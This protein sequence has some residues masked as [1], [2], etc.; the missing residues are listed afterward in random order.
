MPAI[1]PCC[2]RRFGSQKSQ[3]SRSARTRAFRDLAGFGRR[4]MQVSARDAED[5]VLYQLAAVAGVASAE[6]LRLQHVKPHGALFN[7]AARDARSGVGHR[8]GGGGI[9]SPTDSVWPSR[10]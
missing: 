7:M 9:R 10:L 6:G 4:D 5:L 3:A 8:Q 2:G 1:R